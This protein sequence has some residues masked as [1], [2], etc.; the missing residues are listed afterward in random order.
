MTANWQHGA[1][2][3]FTELNYRILQR[4]GDMNTSQDMEEVY[5]GVRDSAYEIIERKG[6]TYYGIGMAA[7]KNQKQS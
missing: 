6:A 4:C 2:Q 5:K 7:E 1:V 3:I